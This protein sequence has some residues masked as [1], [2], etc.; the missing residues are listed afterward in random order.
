MG[1][2][3]SWTE[4]AEAPESPREAG[5][6]LAALAGGCFKPLQGTAF[7]AMFFLCWNSSAWLPPAAF[8]TITQVWVPS[9][10]GN[11]TPAEGLGSKG[12]KG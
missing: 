3:L 9:P 5:A 1:S 12:G 2:M 6:A 7:L 4:G 11:V 8:S 10:G